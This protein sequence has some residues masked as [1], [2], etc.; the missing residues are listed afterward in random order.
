MAMATATAMAAPVAA[1]ASEPHLDPANGEFP[2]TFTASGGQMQLRVGLAT[3]ECTRTN[4]S[5][6]FTSATTGT[7]KLTLEGCRIPGGSACTSPGQA[8][9]TLAFGESVFHLVYLTDNS[10]TAPGVLVTAP[11]GGVFTTSACTGEIKGAGYMGAIEA[12][13]GTTALAFN[14]AFAATGSTQ[15]YRQVEATGT[16]Y[17]M[18]SGSNEVALV[19][20]TAWTF[21]QQATLTCP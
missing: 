10:K 20:T 7:L 6:K 13:C 18:Q 19:Q 15:T 21:P 1:A 11:A 16:V 3:F 2:L 9:G 4:T 5:G 17:N 12:A 8:A 14:V